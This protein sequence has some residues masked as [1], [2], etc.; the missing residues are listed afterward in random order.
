MNPDRYQRIVLTLIASGLLLL[1]LFLLLNGA[2]QMAYAASDALF[3]KSDG[4]GI[5]CTQASPCSLQMAL[6]RA[7]DG[8]TIYVATGTYT[9]TGAAVITMTKSITLY[10]GWN[11]ATSGTVVRDTESYPTT[12]DGESARRG[13]YISGDITPTLDGFIVIRGNASNAT[14]D[15]GYGGGIYSSGANPIVTSNVIT[16][17]VAYTSTTDWAQGGGICIHGSYSARVT[18]IISGNLIAN[19]TASA[20]YLGKGGGL[21]VRYGS[22]VIVSNNTFQGNIAGSAHN[23]VGGGLSLQDS[24]A[25]VSGNSIRSN[26]ATPTG[27]GFGG[28]FYSQFGDVTLSGNIVISNAAQYGAVTFEGNENM[29]LTNNIIAQNP[30]GGVFV[31]GNA[32]S[33]LT[34]ILVHNTIAQNGKEGV[35]AGWFNSGYS[36]LTLINNVIVNHAKGIYA[37]PD[38]NPNVVTATHTLFYGNDDD[39]EGSIITSTNEITGSDPLFVDPAGW[40]YHL[41]AGSPAIEAG[42]T[43]PWLTTDIDSDSRPWPAGGGYDVGADEA[44]WRLVYLPLVMRGSD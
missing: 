23:G 20:A 27:A 28:G 3:V 15:P 40:D 14:T 17:N 42:V 41:Q 8:D 16:N 31:R 22:G 29:T 10:G 35:Y 11:G 19:N 4:A 7:A 33:P 1:G 38:P 13:V 39:T 12:L 9:G 30:A 34:G 36:T 24:S 32:S 44:R 26:R 18:A 25:V 5:N 43:V 2:P 21:Q 37:Y 6:T